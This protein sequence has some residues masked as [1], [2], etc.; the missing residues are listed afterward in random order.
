MAFEIVWTDQANDDLDDIITYLE[1]NWTD[2][3]I[4][5]FFDRLETCLIQIK[6]APQ[7]FKYSLRKEGTKEFQHSPQTTI[8]YSHND[9]AINILRLW[10]NYKDPITIK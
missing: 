10:T 6:S 1:N 2:K 9:Y 4:G 7:R 5:N 8:F 3:E